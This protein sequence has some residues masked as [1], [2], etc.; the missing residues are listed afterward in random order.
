MDAEMG[1]GR[2]DVL[3]EG[4]SSVL[5]GVGEVQLA[6]GGAISMGRGFNGYGKGAVSV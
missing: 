1:S 2:G 3:G 5:V 4:E 6:W